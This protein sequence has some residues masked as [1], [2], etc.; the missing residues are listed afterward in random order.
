MRHIP[1]PMLAG[2][3]LGIGLWLALSGSAQDAA[4][5]KGPLIG[6][7]TG[8]NVVKPP[9]SASAFDFHLDGTGRAIR[10]FIPVWPPT[11]PTVEQKDPVTYFGDTGQIHTK[12]WIIIS[13]TST[14]TGDGYLIVPP[15]Q[16]PSMLAIWSDVNGPAIQVRGGDASAGS[17]LLQGLDHKANYTFSIENAGTLRWGAA[18]RAA[19]DTNLY[20]SAAKTLKTDGSLVVGGSQSVRRTAVKTNYTLT[21]ADYYIGVTDTSAPRTL[22]L[23]AASG[24][25]GRL[26]VVK[27]ESG[28]AGN[29]PITVQ[30]EAGGT[31][32]GA[33]AK[34]IGANYGL[35]RVTS[36][37][38]DWFGM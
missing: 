13:G 36:S 32:D 23:P 5:P 21:D 8:I 25:E 31:I 17:Y 15:T 6:H 34:T 3:T 19:M 11:K 2:I 27:D 18:S 10:I 33:K 30:V 26:Y 7:F 22:T 4:K 24:R 37:G 35:M 16:D 14:G 28:G 29:H 20:R 1:R 12:G 38:K 9:G